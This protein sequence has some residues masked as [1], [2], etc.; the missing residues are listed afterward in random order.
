[1]NH[2]E[3]PGKG[4][5]RNRILASATGL[6]ANFGYNGVSI[7]DIAEHA[8]VNE[9]TIYRHYPRKR[10]LYLAALAAEM[11][12]VKLGG[13]LLA[14]I[15]DARDAK[16]VLTY[17]FELISVTLLT[18][19]ELLRLIQYSALEMGPDLNPLVHRHLG[20]LVEVMV[21]YLEPWVSRGELRCPNAKVLVLSL[22]GIILS[23]RTLDRLFL[24]DGSGL[25]AMFGSFA[26]SIALEHNGN[27]TLSCAA[28][29]TTSVPARS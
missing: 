13:D 3:K 12:Q 15:A 17:T 27:K 14:R 9:V 4:G 8:A 2:E 10:D 1:M 24:G 22:V 7:R 19:P 11:Q 21:R 6:F 25:E 20:Q 18:R 28:G 29:T 23:H 5:V 16:T 26:E